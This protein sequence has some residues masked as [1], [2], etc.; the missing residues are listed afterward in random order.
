MLVSLIIGIFLAGL[1]MVLLNWWA[2]ADVSAARKA[3]FWAIVAL[4]GLFGLI[5]FATGKGFAAILPAGF[6]AWRMFGTRLGAK[7][8]ATGQSG[9]RWPQRQSGMSR[10][11]ALEVL[12]L[13]ASASEDQINATYRK[14][15][16]KYHPDKGG[17]DWMAAKL[18]EARKILLN[19]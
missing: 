4:C 3:L 16:A 10:S 1:L 15:M 14:L 8:G 5:L 19:K 6:A 13:D 18:N 7:P 12:G 2:C 9:N 11:E 17:N